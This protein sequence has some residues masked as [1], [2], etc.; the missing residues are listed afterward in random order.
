MAAAARPPG[1]G[2]DDRTRSSGPGPRLEPAGPLGFA[3]GAQGGKPAGSEAPAAGGD[4]EG[5][6]PDPFLGDEDPLKSAH[7]GDGG[8]T[9]TGISPR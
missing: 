6:P 5:L 9:R 2:V 1:V 8:R 3:H 4:E 7:S